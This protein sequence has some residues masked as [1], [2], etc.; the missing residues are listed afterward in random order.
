LAAWGMGGV[1]NLDSIP[2]TLSRVGS[3]TVKGKRECERSTIILEDM[4]DGIG[5]HDWAML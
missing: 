1:L 2:D 4:D 5:K 3:A